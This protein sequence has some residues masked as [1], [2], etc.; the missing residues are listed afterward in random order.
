MK[1]C[2]LCKKENHNV[3]GNYCVFCG[4]KLLEKKETKKDISKN[5]LN[6]DTKKLLVRSLL[7]LSILFLIIVGIL[8]I[9]KIVVNHPSNDKISTMTQKI[10]SLESE[11]SW[12][13]N[14]LES[15]ENIRLSLE[16]ELSDNSEKIAF[17]DK[18]IVFVL[19]GYGKYYYTY[20]Q[21]MQVTQGK[22]CSFWAYNI[23]QA[24]D[25]GYKSFD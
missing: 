11:V 10:N 24:E 12:L 3:N 23:E 25:L 4:G 13:K 20:D 8:V 14:R 15:S 5:A 6:P 21:M 2:S 18:Y 22:S 1:V 16:K 9:L 17:F 19:E 7:I